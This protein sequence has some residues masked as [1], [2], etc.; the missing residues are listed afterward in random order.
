ML[1]TILFFLL[2]LSI[3]VGVHEAGHYFAARWCG[4]RVLRFSIGFGKPF[5]TWRNKENTEFSLAP[6]PLGGYVRMLDEREGNVAEEDL[7]FTH[8]RQSPQKR[9]F[10]AAA[11][12]L[13][14]FVLAIAI[15]WLISMLGV[16]VVRPWVEA[17]Q[18]TSAWVGQWPEGRVEIV[19][20]D[21]QPVADLRDVQLALLGRLGES[22]E[23]VLGLRAPEGAQYTVSYP[24]ERWLSRAQDPNPFAEL[25]LQFW[26]PERPAIAASIISG[27]AAERAGMRA[28]DRV[29]SVNGDAISGWNEWVDV[30]QRNP[31]TAIVMVVER[32]GSR[33]DITLVPDSATDEQG[34]IVGRA[35]VYATQVDSSDLVRTVRYGPVAAVGEAVQE[36][37]STSGMILSFLK[38]MVVGEA[39]VK[40]LSGPVSIAQVAG[41]SASFG[42]VSFLSFLALLS[43][44]LGIFNLL[45]IPVLDGGHILYYVV[46]LVRGKPLSERVQTIGF[47]VGIALLIGVMVIAF[48]NDFQRF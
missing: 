37:L 3:L 28:E 40:N 45:P 35:G 48:A 47:Q 19:S 36:T 5:L 10:I 17:P 8:N 14:N 30:V 9:I 29:L 44:S 1:T 15:F 25:G 27:G 13:A 4:V 42:L 18:A 21:A 31:D 46:E 38:K 24:I 43:I 12:P 22:G 23:I 2:A 11:G 34:N 16:S 6:I 7:P 32:A 20:V 41:D 33:V 26:R 39:S